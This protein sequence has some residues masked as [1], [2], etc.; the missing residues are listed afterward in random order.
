MIEPEI[1]NWPTVPE[2]VPEVDRDN[3]PP[4]DVVTV[5]LLDRLS[6]FNVIPAIAFVLRG[7]L[8]VKVPVH[9]KLREAALN[10]T[11]VIF[12]AELIVTA[13]KRVVPPATPEK[14]IFPVPAAKVREPGPSKVLEKV[15]AP[16]AAAVEIDVAPASVT[17]PA[18]VTTSPE[19]VVLL[20]LTV[21]LPDWINP[22]LRLRV[23]PDAIVSTPLFT[24][25]R[26]PPFVVVTV[27]L[28]VRAV[29]VRL[30]PVPPVVESAPLKVVV[31]VPAV[32][33]TLTAF[34]AAEAV[35]LFALEIVKAFNGWVAP[36][37]PV[38]VTL[39]A[40]AI[41]LRLRV[42]FVSPLR[43]LLKVIAAPPVV[44][45]ELATVLR[46][47]AT[48]KTNEFPEV[49]IFAPKKIVPVE[50]KLSAFDTILP[51]IERLPP[52]KETE[53]NSP[54]VAVPIE[55]RVIAPAPEFRVTV[56]K[57]PVAASSGERVIAPP[58]ELIVRFVPA[59]STIEVD[60]KVI[61]VAELVKV[62]R[63]PAVKRISVSV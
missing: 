61:G 29:P 1:T 38:N 33:V 31:P 6:P 34:T 2:L 7:P 54:V 5:P 52:V 23:A 35:T 36:T 24:I 25:V 45:V 43:V 39:P 50:E 22:S 13:P 58:A 8:K 62:A 16:D 49:V 27:L 57:S 11:V 19:V 55:E 56:R 28:K 21:P 30:I 9:V 60:V 3:G 63:E 20:R 48:G 14:R 18:K 26:A 10:G 41:R 46:T 37:A 42:L 12:V 47:T 4:F 51:R 32:C 15:I 59:E 44:S 40:P 53:A 17:A